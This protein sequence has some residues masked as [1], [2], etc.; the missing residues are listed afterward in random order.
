MAGMST[1]VTLFV[2]TAMPVG[3]PFEGGMSSAYTTKDNMEACMASIEPVK[4]ILTSGGVKVVTI[5]CLTT[6]Q[7]ITQFQHRPPKDAPRYAILNRIAGDKLMLIPQQSEKACQAAYNQQV[8]D[9]L[10]HYCS[11]SKQELV[12]P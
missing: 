10:R 12:K 11:T 4:E 5:E 6:G 8:K 7:P 2:L 3:T 9:G 1:F